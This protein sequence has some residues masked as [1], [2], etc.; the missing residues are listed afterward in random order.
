MERKSTAIW[1]GVIL[2]VTA[3]TL[4]GFGQNDGSARKVIAKTAPTYPDIA[5]KMKLTGKVK[6]EVVITPSGAVTSAK[7]VGGSPVFERN[8]VDAVKQWR[9]APADKETKTVVLV[10]FT[11]R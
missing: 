5:R 1:L 2:C 9:F 10:E 7:F 6:V 4:A 8:A 3:L 11:D